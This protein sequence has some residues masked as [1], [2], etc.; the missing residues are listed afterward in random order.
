MNIEKIIAEFFGLSIEKITDD[1]SPRT[2]GDWDSMKHI[3]LILT[4]EK[5]YGIRFKASEIPMLTSVG[6]IKKRIEAR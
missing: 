2:I 6:N 1:S 4:L 5:E 3:E